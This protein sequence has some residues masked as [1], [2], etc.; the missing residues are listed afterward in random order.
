MRS[1]VTSISFFFFLFDYVLD[2]N[3][4]SKLK[5]VEG[6][7]EKYRILPDKIVPSLPEFIPIKSSESQ[8][9]DLFG[10]LSSFS[11]SLNESYYNFKT[12]DKFPPAKSSSQF[13]QFL[14][15]I[16]EHEILTTIRT[17]YK[18]LKNVA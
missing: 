3:D 13:K 9:C 14:H 18:H 5:S 12:E 6:N 4:I 10:N 16:D 1:L 7:L 15:I 11:C 2:S 8:L 17:D